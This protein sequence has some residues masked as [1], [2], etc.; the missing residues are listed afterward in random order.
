MSVSYA[1]RKKITNIVNNLSLYNNIYDIAEIISHD[2]RI[3]KSNYTIN[4][5]GVHIIANNLSDKTFKDIETYINTN[6]K[7]A[8]HT[9][10]DK[11]SEIN[12]ETDRL[13]D[14]IRVSSKEKKMIKRIQYENSNK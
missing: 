7:N 3:S 5:C 11:P 2:A 9:Y 8:H 6:V 10:S 4:N 14:N 13:M 1:R 12:T